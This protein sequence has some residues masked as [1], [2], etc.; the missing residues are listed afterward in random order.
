VLL[1]VAIPCRVVPMYRAEALRYGAREELERLIRHPPAEDGAAP[2]LADARDRLVRAVRIDPDNG[3]AW[4]DLADASLAEAR[5]RRAGIVAL[6]KEAEAAATQALARSRVVPEFWTR[7]GRAFDLQG[8]W[9]DAS[10]DFALAIALAPRR[11]DLW[12]SYAYH[13]SLRDPAGARAALATCLELD[14]WN[15]PA[16]A[17]RKR[18]ENGSP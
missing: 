3:C 14:P 8:R 12:C 13:L 2:L 15:S 6:G 5:F 7:R 16:L 17:L 4:S 10:A 9:C 1:A 18:L 11:S